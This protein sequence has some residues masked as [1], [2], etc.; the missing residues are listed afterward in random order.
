MRSLT[1]SYIEQ[2]IMRRNGCGWLKCFVMEELEIPR[3]GVCKSLIASFFFH[4]KRVTFECVLHR[5]CTGMASVI[6]SGAL[7]LTAP[8]LQYI[9]WLGNVCVFD[10]NWISHQIEKSQLLCVRKAY[11]EQLW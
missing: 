4:S 7:Q 11:F 8:L 6:Q 1:S 5:I 9:F 3:Q 2:R 10:L